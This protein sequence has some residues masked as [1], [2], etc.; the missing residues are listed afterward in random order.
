MI[1]VL[2][3]GTGGPKLLL[4]L[5]RVVPQEEITVIVNTAEDE[6]L[7]HGYLSPDIDTVLYTLSGRINE[8]TWHGRRGDTFAGH[9]ELLRLGGDEILRIGDRDRALHI[10]RGK[11]MKEGATL[12]E[13]AERLR[14]SLGVKARVLPMS[15][16]PVETVIQ[17]T[18]GEMDLHTYLIRERGRPE[19][20]KVSFRGIEAAGAPPE[21][22]AA[23]EEADWILY[24][25]S[26]P[27][28]S[29]RPI[30]S[31][32]ELGRTLRNRR[33]HGIA[34]SPIVGRRPVSGPADRFMRALGHS[35]D[36]YHVALLYREFVSRFVIDASDEGEKK[37]IEALR[38]RCRSTEIVM[39]GPREREGLARFLI[40]WMG[41]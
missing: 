31:V 6:W 10:V 11:W 38:M 19:V 27:V 34:V 1:T 30:L 25:P 4:G 20:L 18:Q 36:P 23:V 17:T 35:V 7:P 22:L 12:T 28:S 16:D 14:R 3:G 21:A 8:E 33:S 40:E 5:I 15:N 41:V 32:R 39:K 37:K 9:E 13:T 2:S 24:G 26:N 29:L